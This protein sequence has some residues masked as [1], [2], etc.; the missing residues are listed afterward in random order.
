M[1]K[2]IKR[3]Q[4]FISL[5]I[6]DPERVSMTVFEI[7]WKTQKNFTNNMSELYKINYNLGSKI[8]QF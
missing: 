2:E 6:K 4:E 1:V 5:K 3:K 8:R 7:F